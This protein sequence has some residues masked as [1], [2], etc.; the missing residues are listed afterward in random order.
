MFVSLSVRRIGVFHW[1]NLVGNLAFFKGA[2]Q[3]LQ[4]QLGSVVVSWLVELGRQ[5]IK[6]V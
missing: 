1:S 6:H 3:C 4:S 2:E 5:N